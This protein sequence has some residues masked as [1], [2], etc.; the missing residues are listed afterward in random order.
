MKILIDGVFFQLAKGGISR[1][2]AS[3]LTRLVRVPGWEIIFLNR[4][5]HPN[6]DGIRYINFPSYNGK[7]TASDS[8]LIERYARDVG[9]D[10][11]ASTY[12][13]TP[14]SIP[15]V[16]IV[17]DMIPE[18][19]G[20][21]LSSQW[22]QEKAIAIDYARQYLCV[23]DNTRRDLLRI[24]PYLDPARV[25]TQYC[26]I[27]G[28]IFFPRDKE[29]VACFRTRYGLERAYF[30][31]VGSR[32]QHANYKNTS[33]FFN[34]L[35][36]MRTGDFDVVCVGGGEMESDL[37]RG[38]GD[39][40][41][42]RQ[43]DFDDDELASAYSGA[44]AL[45]FPSLYEGFGLPVAEAMACGCP[46]ITTRHGSLGEV[47]GEAALYV[48]GDSPGEM[49]QAINEIMLNRQTAK[50][51]ALGLSR[52]RFFSWDRMAEVLIG[53]LEAAVDEGYQPKAQMFFAEW[54]R[55]RAIQAAVDT[56]L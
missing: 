6:I 32:K 42:I 51:R 55:L 18:V 43:F 28:G 1:V 9:A 21:D 15:S 37:L 50:L 54:S 2:W 3:L 12:Y 33:L 47:S 30:V 20:F 26:G 19:L 5:G 34:A 7:N 38:G 16:L 44:K 22:W 52:A 46:V 29:E 14:T 53:L 39:W 10:V 49:A 36:Q 17:H 56:S 27:E 40:C 45:V 48:S 8:L 25:H 41:S 11:F 13:T 23:S 24:H 31:V 35:K 4:G